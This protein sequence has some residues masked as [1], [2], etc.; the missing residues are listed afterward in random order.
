MEVRKTNQLIQTQID[1]KAEVTKAKSAIQNLIAD[2][3]QTENSQSSSSDSGSAASSEPEKKAGQITNGI[4]IKQMTAARIGGTNAKQSS[5]VSG[6]KDLTPEQQASVSNSDPQKKNLNPSFVLQDS[7]TKDQDRKNSGLQPPFAPNTGFEN[8]R[9]SKVGKDQVSN[10]TSSEQT[11][12]AVK[13]AD[14]LVD[15]G[16]LRNQLGDEVA[17]RHQDSTGIGGSTNDRL[18]DL[19]NPTAGGPQES[20]KAGKDQLAY[21][22]ES[23]RTNKDGS[24]TLVREE[25]GSIGG[26]SSYV[27]NSES[28]FKDG[29]QIA[30]H[31]TQ[32]IYGTD[33][34]TVIDTKNTFDSNG[35]L[36]GQTKTTT[37]SNQD[38]SYTSTETS[39]RDKNGKTTSNKTETTKNAD[40]S[41]TTTTSTTTPSGGGVKSYDQENY[42][43]NIPDAVKKTM[44]YFK[45]QAISQ[46]PS[47]GGE[48]AHTD[49]NA[50]ADPTIGGTVSNRVAQQGAV[51]LFGNPGSPTSE[52]TDKGRTPVASSQGGGNV[53]FGPD[54]D[55][56]GYTGPTHQDDPGDVEFGS[57]EPVVKGA[58]QS[59]NSDDDSSDSR[60]SFDILN[61][62]GR[63]SQ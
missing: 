59:K 7:R 40:G 22:H 1:Q 60:T 15:G 36:S 41:T 18:N 11:S 58:V 6:K 47:T 50:E 13:D 39:T 9:F 4:L 33:T 2:S 25:G 14:R 19:L 12:D 28:T 34:K 62:K 5:E 57:Q 31:S 10:T 51:G 29:K 42:T 61:L 49:D 54:S 20:A 63:K 16:S 8:S 45:Q 43:G 32:T 44:E 27:L 37:T 48:T 52:N 3:F 30:G 53:D 38:G 56:V 21:A 35:R 26:G 46:K 55:Q 23:T 24:T 17:E